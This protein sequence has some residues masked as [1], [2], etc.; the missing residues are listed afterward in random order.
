[1]IVLVISFI[2]ILLC[3]AGIGVKVLVQKNGQFKRHCA[4]RDP[5]TG[6]TAGCQCEAAKLCNEKKSHPYQALDVN[7]ELMNEMGIAKGH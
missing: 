6:D 7:D 2:I 1:M 5:Y 4:S 3:I